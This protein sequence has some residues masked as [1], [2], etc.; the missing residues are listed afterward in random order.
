MCWRERVIQA[1]SLILP[2]RPDRGS[3]GKRSECRQREAYGCNEPEADV[4]L[5]GERA[6]WAEVH[7]R[8]LGIDAL[9]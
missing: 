3:G 1:L 5:T 2:C 7:T 6:R 4:I 8:A 9:Q